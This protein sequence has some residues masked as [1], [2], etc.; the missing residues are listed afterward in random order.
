MCRPDTNPRTRRGVPAHAFP[1]HAPARRQDRHRHRGARPDRRGAGSRQTAPVV[2][3]INGH[4]YRS[5]LGSMGGVHKLPVSAE[6]RAAAGISAGDEVD[7]ELRLDD[8][9]REVAVPDDLAAALRADS[10]AG[11]AFDALSPSRRRALVQ[12]LEGAK[13]AETRQRRLAK[14]IEGL[15]PA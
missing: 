7:V 5:T 11:R 9:P 4:T 2:V 13:T 12:Q 6:H 15:H 3:Q 8:Q 10:A 14:A 1:R